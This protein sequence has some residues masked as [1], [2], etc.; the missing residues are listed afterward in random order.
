MAT[1]AIAVFDSGV[2]GLTV[3]KSLLQHF[4]NESFVYFGDNAR[5]PY[6]SKGPSTIRRFCTENLDFLC[7][8]G[9]KAIV[10][11][12]NTA[13]TQIHEDSW[14]GVPIYTVIEPGAQAALDCSENGS[15]LVLGTRATIASGVY[16]E[17]LLQL[18]A[19]HSRWKDKK[20][21]IQVAACPLFVPLAEEGWTE[22]PITN[23]VAFRY[24]QQFQQQSSDVD[25]AI[26]GCTHYPLLR[27]AIQ[28][29]LGNYV[30]LVES[31]EAVSTK[32]KNDLA[33]NRLP[34]S[35]DPANSESHLEIIASDFNQ[36]FKDLCSQILTPQLTHTRQLKWRG[37]D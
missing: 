2:G 27:T 30:Q 14:K 33:N 21:R 8:L 31:G 10:V 34:A 24:L 19:N 6:G 9:V 17:K 35:I 11:A 13:S 36:S 16:P 20:I 3:L 15:I 1:Q 12:C 7:G 28:K 4:P 26:L 22:D 37:L 18:A 29:V 5:L 32:L 23:L 25:C